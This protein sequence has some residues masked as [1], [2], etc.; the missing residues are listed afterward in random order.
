MKRVYPVYDPHVTWGPT[1]RVLP[2]P[3]LRAWCCRLFGRLFRNLRLYD[4]GMEPEMGWATRM[5]RKV[6]VDG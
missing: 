2:R 4:R 3:G 1:G 5:F 6:E